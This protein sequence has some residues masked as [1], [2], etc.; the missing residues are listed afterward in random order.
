[1]RIANNNS[2]NLIRQKGNKNPKSKYF[3]ISEGDLT[4]IQYFNGIKENSSDL[5]INSL[6]EIIIVENDESEKGESH[7]LIKIKN[8]RSE[9]EN[10]TI[11]YD[12]EIDKVCFIFD[13]DPQNFKDYQYDEFIN[14]CKSNAFCPYISNPTFEFFL[15]LHSDNI[16][17]LNK[18]EMLLNK[19]ENMRGKRFLEKKLSE[20]FGF[21]KSHINFNIL[22]NNI[23]KAIKN[24]KSFCEDILKLKDKL[25]SNVGLL[26]EQMIDN[27]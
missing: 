25:G 19:K 17:T 16:F 5:S 7:P 26:I 14:E 23:K 20:L 8:F 22:K 4:E 27:N 10:N 1:M 9:I 12:K 2:V 11:I 13:R 15:L 24:E 6:I 21:N 18:D 3:I